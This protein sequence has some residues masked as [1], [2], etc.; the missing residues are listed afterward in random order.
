MVEMKEIDARGFAC[1]EPVLM[2]KRAAEAGA[3]AIII[4]VDNE[5]ATD[6]VSRFAK[7]AGFSADIAKAGDDFKVTLKKVGDVKTEDVEIECGTA[8]AKIIKDKV[9][10]IT[11]DSLGRDDRELGCLLVKVMLN[12]LAENDALPEKIIFMNAGVKLCC[13]GSES[14]DAL[15]LLLSQGVDVMVC[16]TCLK[17]FELAEKLQAGRVSNAYEIMNASLKGNVYPWS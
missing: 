13:D 12:A 3:T 16:G 9:L 2:T 5:D 6:N 17:H 10:M 11:S 8:N 4:L 1:P 15:K 14:L 7:K